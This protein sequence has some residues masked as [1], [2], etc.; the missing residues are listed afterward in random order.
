MLGGK[1]LPKQ[2]ILR[3][4]FLAYSEDKIK[5]AEQRWKEGKFPTIPGDD[6]EHIPLP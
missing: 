4:N 6:V 2:P 1:K 3:W 5:Q